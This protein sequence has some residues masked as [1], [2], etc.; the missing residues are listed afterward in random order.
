MDS[1]QY[2]G[3]NHFILD[4]IDFLFLFLFFCMA[5]CVQELKGK[6]GLYVYISSD[7]IYEVTL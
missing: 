5:K 3:N 6:V 4:K 1:R 2:G 7:S